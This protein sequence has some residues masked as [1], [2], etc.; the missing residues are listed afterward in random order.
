M[1]KRHASRRMQHHLFREWEIPFDDEVSSTRRNTTILERQIFGRT[2][3]QKMIL[4]N[5]LKKAHIQDHNN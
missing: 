5:M 1:E 4:L 2:R 3:N